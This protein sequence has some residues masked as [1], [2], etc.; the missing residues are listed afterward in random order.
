MQ[1]MIKKKEW[2]TNW[3]KN[4]YKFQKHLMKYFHLLKE[5]YYT[6]TR[7]DLFIGLPRI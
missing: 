3:H 6:Y 2:T 4:M 5:N 7:Y 1:L